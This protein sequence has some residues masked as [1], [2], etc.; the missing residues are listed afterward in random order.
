MRGTDELRPW[1]RRS[2]VPLALGALV[3]IVVAWRFVAP[4]SRSSGQPDAPARSAPSAVVTRPPQEWIVAVVGAVRH[5]GV[6]K[7]AG[8]TR[9]IQALRLAGGPTGN[10]DLA[11]INLAAPLADGQQVVVPTRPPA[12]SATPTT[13]GRRG[14]VSLTSA[15]AEELE[16]LDGI[17]PALAQR[18]VHWRTTNGFHRI[19]D[20]LNVPG[21]GDAKLSAIRDQIVP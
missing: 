8:E 3:L 18:I 1:L 7:I 17:G 2:G 11:A 5:P 21:I 16:A 12:G 4:A 15:T 19:E 20:L 13:A 14:P 10:A 9:V 6:Y